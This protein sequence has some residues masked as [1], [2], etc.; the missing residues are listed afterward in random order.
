MSRYLSEE[1]LIKVIKQYEDWEAYEWSRQDVID[2]V[3]NDENVRAVEVA[4]D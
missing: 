1:D 3:L 2:Y 4:D